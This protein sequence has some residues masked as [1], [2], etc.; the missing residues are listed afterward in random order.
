[1]RC[2]RQVRSSG[3]QAMPEAQLPGHVMQDHPS[4]RVPGV[5][6][7]AAGKQVQV[8]G[9]RYTHVALSAVTRHR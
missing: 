6:V 4:C 7:G 2:A 5:H 8:S 9:A 3:S 1:M